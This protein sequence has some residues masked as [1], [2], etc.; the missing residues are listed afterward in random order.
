L[1]K[2]TRKYDASNRYLTLLSHWA[3]LRIGEVSGLRW[4]D[5]TTTRRLVKD[6]NRLLPDMTKV[7]HARTVFFSTKQKAELPAA[8][9]QATCVNRSYPL[10]PAKKHQAEVQ[11]QQDSPNLCTDLRGRGYGRSQQPQRGQD[12]FDAFGKPMHCHSPAQHADRSKQHE[13][14]F[15]LPLQQPPFDQG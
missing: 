10:L 2:N 12:I 13:L 8:A 4:S 11:L 3:G 14:N 5:F 9:E 1:F 15:C 7:R 6:E